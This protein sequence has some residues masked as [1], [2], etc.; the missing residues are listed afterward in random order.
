[1]KIGRRAFLRGAGGLLVGLPLLEMTHGR[2]WGAGVTAEKRFVVVFR[3]GGTVSNI[4][5]YEPNTA[6]ER[7]DGRGTE[8]GENY[9]N[10][11]D[12]GE[13]LVLGPI[14]SILEEHKSDLLVVTGV[15]NQAGVRQGPYLGAHGVANKTALTAA[16]VEEI[17][18]GDSVD[19]LS[20]GPSIDQVL[21]TRLAARTPTA[22]HSVSLMV[23]GHQYGTPFFSGPRQA[24]EGEND[25]GRAFD[26]YLAGV[27]SGEPDPAILLRRAQDV[28]VLDGVMDGYRAI[29]PRLSS[30]DRQVVD[31]H[32]THLRELERRIQELPVVACTVPTVE[33]VDASD[34]ERVGSLHVDILLAALRCGLTNVGTLNIADIITPW[35]GEPFGPVGYDIG[36]S[37]HHEASDLGEASAKHPQLGAWLEE[38]TSNRQWC[39]GLFKRLLEGLK[40]V[41]EGDGTMLTNSL[42]LYTSEFSN[43]S[44]HSNND[45]PLLL[46]GQAGGVFRT[47]RHVNCNLATD[48]LGYRSR[49]STHNLF[50]SIV[51]AFGFP[52]EHFGNDMVEFRGPLPGLT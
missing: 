15:D 2:S 41:P 12:P 42:L 20:L 21:A 46:A 30:Q 33:A 26:T 45:V 3:H 49:T 37:L 34:L 39:L 22:Y 28:S 10:P 9:W 1:M 18:S 16:D 35:L 23:E 31:A 7:L 8:Q 50:T 27:T 44:V 36:H 11:P 19:Y 51:N 40:A 24:V 17:G 6:G 47:G 43:G 13:A 25:P 38:M 5:R 4:Y 29:Q 48:P 32:L 14:H 52:D